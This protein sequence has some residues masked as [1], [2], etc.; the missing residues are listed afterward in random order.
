MTE[1]RAEEIIAAALYMSE[2]LNRTDIP[3]LQSNGVSFHRRLDADNVHFI[4][5]SFGGASVLRAAH[6][7]AAMQA[8]AA[9][10]SAAAD[11]VMASFLPPR[12]RSVVAH[13]PASDWLPESTRQS[14]FDVER[15]ADSTANHTYWTRT[16]AATTAAMTIGNHEEE[17]HPRQRPRPP[18]SSFSIHDFDLFLLFSHEWRQQNWGG[19]DVLQDMYLRQVFGRSTRAT[20]NDAVGDTDL[21][22]ISRVNIADSAHHIEFSDLCMITPTWLA[23]AVGMTG[24]NSPLE[25]AKDIHT[26]TLKFLMEVQGQQQ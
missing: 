13:D 8:A 2:V 10:G 17:E 4:G 3:A 23:R 19:V 16:A 25:T 22:S 5:H 15:L 26:R 6:K 14:L 24:T 20:P 7:I 12:P 21:V 1:Y 9:A 11:T 18:T